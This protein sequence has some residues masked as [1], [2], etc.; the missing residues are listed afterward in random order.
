MQGMRSVSTSP[1]RLR[2]RSER[3]V[4]VLAALSL[5]PVGAA[6]AADPVVPVTPGAAAAAAPT[7]TTG[8]PQAPGTATAPAPPVVSAFKADRSSSQPLGLSPDGVDDP[9][10]Y[11]NQPVVL[12]WTAVPGAR[13]YKVEIATTAGFAKVVWK[14]ETDQPLTAPTTLLPDGDYYWRVTATD[15]ASTIGITSEVARFAKRWPNAVSGLAT[16][17]TP[18]GRPISQVALHPYFTWK[19]VPGATN[20]DVEVAAGDRFASPAMTST[21]FPLTF[22]TP[23]SKFVLSDDSYSWRVRAKDLNGQPGPWSSSSTFTKVWVTPTPT[24]PADDAAVKVP[25]LRWDPV[26]G[27]EGYQ[28]QISEHPLTFT[29]ALVVINQET[30]NTA[31]S[32]IYDDINAEHFSPGNHYFWRVRPLVGGKFGGWTTPRHLFWELP[33]S[34]APAMTLDPVADIDASLPPVFSWTPMPA[35]GLYRVDIATDLAFHNIINQEWTTGGAYAPSKPLPDNSTGTGYF[36]RVVWG[37]GTP[38][39]HVLAADE[40]SVPVGTFK[41]QTRFT[42]GQ[43][44]STAVTQPPLLSWAPVV[45]AAKYDL[46]ISRDPQ[47]LVGSLAGANTSLF[48]LGL[49]PTNFDDAPRLGDGTWFWRVRVKDA[50]SIGQSWSQPGSFT[51]ITDHPDPA[52]PAD[53]DSVAGAPLLRWSPVQ[54]ACGYDVQFN[55][56]PTLTEETKSVSTS[57]TAYSLTGTDIPTAG[58]WYWRVRAN[59]CDQVTS[60]WSP[61]RS[62]ISVQPPDFGLQTMPRTVSYGRKVIVAGKLLFSGRAVRSP[63]LIVERKEGADS[64]FRGYGT[65]QGDARGRFA[66]SFR[67]K[68]SAAYRLRWAAEASHPEGETNFSVNVAPRVTARLLGARVLRKGLVKVAGT[69]YPIRTVRVQ[70]LSD[71]NWTTLATFKPKAARFKVTAKAAVDAGRYQLRLIVPGDKRLAQASTSNRAL[72]VYDKFTV[73]KAGK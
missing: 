47:F 18:G 44:A 38:D 39:T 11:P 63:K 73:Q 70:V 37:S 12:R 30:A 36:W 49:V 31:W 9:L 20:Y 7:T 8:T 14:G 2:Q 29:G 51:L 33:S 46:E 1:I 50:A 3:I 69:I 35:A 56:Q 62:F 45:G 53:D 61:T 26:E 28:V 66:F 57:Q 17:S 68:A 19:P 16:A 34:T 5:V 10:N 23:S 64:K 59:M 32:P 48:G 54:T 25:L 22:T 52:L 4:F 71:G 15:Q 27:A 42:L 65:I 60:D 41:K 67:P 58:R 43:G 55:N 24:A 72:L 13:T 40:N 6:I 21:N